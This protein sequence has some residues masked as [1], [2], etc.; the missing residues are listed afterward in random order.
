MIFSLSET[1]LE[2]SG[3]RDNNACRSFS[4]GKHTLLDKMV[5]PYTSFWLPKDM[6]QRVLANTLR[7]KAATSAA[8]EAH[9]TKEATIEGMHQSGSKV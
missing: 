9:Q 8:Y 6:Q 3:T 5:T 1:R 4:D 2:D 7:E